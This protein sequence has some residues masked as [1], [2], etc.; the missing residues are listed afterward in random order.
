MLY[1][2]LILL[3]ALTWAQVEALSLKVRNAEKDDSQLDKEFHKMIGIP[4]RSEQQDV[5]LANIE[6]SKLVNEGVIQQADVTATNDVQDDEEAALDAEFHKLIGFP[7]RSEEQDDVLADIEMK[8]LID[9]GRIE[10]S[11]Q[12]T[13][14]TI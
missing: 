14:L 2:V 7:H 8:R 9:E 13:L 12:W 1:S 10:Q 3:S 4:H 11:L 6:M 5:L